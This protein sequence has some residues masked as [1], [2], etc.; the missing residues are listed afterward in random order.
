MSDDEETLT[1]EEAA[2]K[3]GKN[4][5]TIQRYIKEGLLT[6]LP[7]GELDSSEVESL[8]DTV[9]S[10]SGHALSELRKSLAATQA[11]VN[12]S[13]RLLLESQAQT[14]A[15]LANENTRLAEQNA[16]YQEKHVS[17]LND[18][19]EILLKKDER[20]AILAGEEHRMSMRTHAFA[21]FAQFVPEL[22][23]QVRDGS[24][25]KQALSSLSNDEMSMLKGGLEVLGER[26]K[27]LLNMV[28]K[29]VPDVET[30]KEE[31]KS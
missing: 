1:I 13:I 24:K 21:L 5:R 3:L 8:S 27:P 10:D 11:H 26:G 30:A 20:T 16:V 15:A 7:T 22:M 14:L 12:G 9:P 18:F 28:K 31:A 19:G 23:S 29:A 4:K 25:I 17:L 6:K 2:S